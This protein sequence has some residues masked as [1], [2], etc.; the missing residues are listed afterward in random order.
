VNENSF[1]TKKGL[2][3]FAILMIGSLL[4]GIGTQMTQFALIAWVYEKTGSALSAGILATASYGSVIVASIF[5]GAFVDKFNRKKMIILTDIIASLATVLLLTI[6]SLDVMSSFVL[7]LY[8]IVR[9]VVGSVQFPAYMSIITLMV[10]AG[11]RSRANGM[12]QTASSLSTTLSPALAGMLLGFIGIE[13]IFLIDIF[14]FLFI[15]C[16]IIFIK[17]PESQKTTEQN[18]RT[19]LSD[20]IDGFR[21]L[22]ARMSLLGF[23]LV[24]TFYNI[25]FGA[26]EGLYR[27]MLLAFSD[28]SVKIAGWALMGYGIGNVV[29][30]VF[31]TI[32]KGPKNRVPLTLL[33]WA[34]SGLFGFVVGGWGRSLPVWIISGFL[35]GVFNNIAVVLTVGIWQ[36]KVEPA[37]QGRV[38]GI[39]KLVA[40]VTIP[41]A[42]FVM[43]FISDKV[44]IPGFKEGGILS[45]LF[46]EYVGNGPGAG[47]SFVLIVSGLLFGVI[48]PLIMF[49]FPSLRNADKSEDSSVNLAKTVLKG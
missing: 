30:G 47:M 16:T 41:V 24:L 25:A 28:N 4:S 12:Y 2:W 33:A 17:I 35:Q 5:A 31:M 11:Q 7:I 32:W 15:I 22:F 40:Q 46:G 13:Q 23:V 14:T 38:F 19:I 34:I 3:S 45:N 6:H 43:T 29:S 26:Y 36:S 44:A 8:G 18:E 21:Y 10:P 48:S 1:T 9:G 20:T 27:P 37:F 49:V 39:M 42:V